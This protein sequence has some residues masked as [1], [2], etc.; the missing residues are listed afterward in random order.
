[1]VT[2]KDHKFLYLLLSLISLILLTPLLIEF[3]SVNLTLNVFLTGILLACIFA[4]AQRGRQRV[5]GVM[6]ASPYLLTIWV[7]H[8]YESHLTM[9]IGLLSGICYFFYVALTLLVNILKVKEVDLETIFG[10]ISAYLL[11]G[12]AWSL[13]Y[14]LIEY[15]QS[16]SFSFPDQVHGEQRY[17]FIYFSF[18]TLTTLGYGDVTPNSAIAKALCIL[19]ATIGQIYLV[20]LVAGLV[21]LYISA[22][23]QSGSK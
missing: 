9:I 2:L 16:D 19:E 23:P 3:S 7:L 4:S 6:L 22:K 5:F 11:M 14:H 12:L 10:A 20:V 21:G 8:F 17:T 15:L 1:M 18:V 13:I